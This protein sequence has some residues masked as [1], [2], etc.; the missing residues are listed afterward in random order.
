MP[1]KKPK[2]QP[3]QPY[4][5]RLQAGTG[6]RSDLQAERDTI[7]DLYK[8]H[9]RLLLE[10]NIFLYAVTGV[11]LSFVMAHLEVPHIRWVAGFPIVFD[12]VFAIFFLLAERGISYNETELE[13]IS[14]ALKV[15]VFPRLDALKLGLWI[16][17]AALFLTALLTAIATF[18]IDTTR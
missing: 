17:S 16:S 3:L 12:T 2:D 15:N 11:L 14:V 8:H 7:L 18:L 13:L 5:D 9:L 10:A 4:E 1:D 6:L